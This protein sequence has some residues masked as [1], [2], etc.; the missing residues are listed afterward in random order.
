MVIKVVAFDLDD[1]L[2]NATDLSW[3]AR[4]SGLKAMISKGLNIELK[5][6]SLILNEIVKEYGSNN[7]NH[8]N[9]FIRRINRFEPQIEFISSSKKNMYVTTAVMAYHEQKIKMIE[10]FED[11]VPCLR[12]IK[13]MGIKTA[14]I[15]DGIPIKQY[16]KILRL[17]ID[18]FVDLI[19]ISDE[20][21]VRK[22]NPKLFEYCL[23]KFGI[24]GEE[25]IYVGDNPV[26]DLIPARM[27]GM[28]SVYIHRGGKYDSLTTGEKILTELRPDY[29][30]NTLKN[31]KEIIKE[32]NSK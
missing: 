30:I 3:E 32:I 4:I 24:S 17:G 2:F 16:E 20:I 21:G 31:F 22:P 29:E 26:K 6:A 15:S 1:T 18:E 12:E 13:S 10:P 5:K 25:S 27:N 9:I 28:F 19:V 11:V 23:K 14:I 8:Y 7:S